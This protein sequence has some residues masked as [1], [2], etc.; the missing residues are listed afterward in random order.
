MLLAVLLV[1]SVVV[2]GAITV[3]AEATDVA[4]AEDF[5]A[6]TDGEY[7]LTEDITLTGT[8]ASFS[9]TL[10]GNGHTVTVSA[11]VFGTLSGTV[12]N[13]TIEGEIVS[14]ATGAVGAL[15]ST[16]SG[17]LTLENVTNKASVTASGANNVGGLI[18]EVKGSSGITVSITKCKNEGAISA[19]SQV[20]GLIGY[21]YNSSADYTTVSIT[22][23]V[24][25]GS[26]SM[27]TT[28]GNKGAGGFIGFGDKYT[29]V[30]IDKS[31]NSGAISATGGDY[32]VAGFYGGG[33]WARDYQILS[34]KNSANLGSVTI[35]GS[36][37]RGRIG[38]FVG[39]W[40]RR[41]LSC[42][43]ENCYNV[44]PI[45]GCGTSGNKDGA[46]GLLGYTN[47]NDKGDTNVITIKNC[48]NIGTVTA[49]YG[50]LSAIGFVDNNNKNHTVSEN[51]FYLAGTAQSAGNWVTGTE[52]ADKDALNA[53]LLALEN[54]PYIV[55][56][57]QNDGYAI[58]AWQCEH[59]ETVVTCLGNKCTSCGV[60]VD[61][62]GS[63]E[64]SYP[65]EW[66]TVDPAT[67]TEDGLAE[68]ICGICQ[69]KE[70]KT[71]DALGKIT[72]VDGVYGV[73]TEDQLVWLVY[74]INKG[75]IEAN[76][77][78]ALKAD[79]TLTNGLDMIIPTFNGSFDG[80][81]HTISGLNNALFKRVKNG[82]VFKNVTLNGDI[83]Y[84]AHE[85][86]EV[87][88]C[89]ASV[90]IYAEE[91]YLLENVV[92]NVNITIN[93]TNLNAA[94]LIGFANAGTIKNCT[95]AGTYT[96]TWTSGKGGAFGGMVG[97]LNDNAADTYITDCLFSG[98][99]VLTNAEAND[100]DMA[101]GGIVGRARNDAAKETITGCANIGT[102]EVTVSGS[103]IYVGGIVGAF[104]KK[105]SNSLSNSVFNGTITTNAP[106]CGT[107]VG[108]AGG[109]VPTTNCVSLKEGALVGQ[110][111]LAMTAC[112]DGASVEK[113]G[114]EFVRADV[115]YQKY[116]FGYLR[117][118][119]SMLVNPMTIP[120]DSFKGTLTEADNG[121]WKIA[122]DRYASFIS[123]RNGKK[124]TTSDLR[125]VLAANLAALDQCEELYVQIAFVKDGKTVVTLSKKLTEDLSVY[126]SVI[127]AGL[128]YTAEENVVL[129]G[130]VITDAPN[131]A[132]DE[133]QVAL[134]DGE[135]PLVSGKVT[136]AEAGAVT[137]GID[138]IA[139]G[140]GTPTIEDHHDVH[141]KNLAYASWV[142]E[143]D[144]WNVL[145]STG[146]P[147][148][149]NGAF[150]LHEGY[151]ATVIV[152]GNVRAENTFSYYGFT[153]EGGDVPIYGYFRFEVGSKEELMQNS[154]SCVLSVSLKIEDANGNV[155]C[156]ANFEDIKYT[157]LPYWPDDENPG[158]E[159]LGVTAISGPTHSTEGHE[160]LYDDNVNTKLCTSNRT[161][162]VFSLAEA[163]A[164]SGISLVTA[165]DNANNAGQSYRVVSGFTLYGCSTN[166]ENDSDWAIVLDVD[167]ANMGKDNFTEYY[168]AIDGASEYQY[169][170]IVFDGT[171]LF[172]F[173]ELWVYGN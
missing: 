31:L 59:K 25:A 138:L 39:R 2:I 26:V 38:G 133:V 152:N 23:S 168:Y 43:L 143:G 56:P 158:A 22:D 123:S 84:T 14:D 99:M 63:G 110:G 24:N 92:S 35:T 163:K 144:G 148:T 85:D 124:A 164:L 145:M 45:T 67:V 28:E 54:T 9:G 112:Y 170:K 95:Y 62:T 127:A 88:R 171:N 73:A 101:I 129:F 58:L 128:T 154:T 157:T 68:R 116:N 130:L 12:K 125:F 60:L 126:R 98:K 135:L 114:D 90:V 136:P 11:P 96:A 46:S 91:G 74:H 109:E 50:T 137:E 78:I 55:A 102:I 75:D 17:N 53:A 153:A 97:W 8:L 142:P 7:K 1:A 165:N 49:K 5:A 156:Y 13:L 87:H 162:V 167:Q 70:T 103:K 166:S 34:I 150:A 146:A 65:D 76:V 159:K 94:G 16:V 173:S 6:M 48:Y 47:S 161:P 42:T 4:S 30:S 118:D 61:E 172:Q 111:T 141:N 132:W 104:N 19:A 33:T 21:L 66:T 89:A 64:H 151:T 37:N 36:N 81:G 139:N 155:V 41:A 117:E 27:S 113:L 69:N 79:I 3:S 131:N 140:M 147:V 83:D 52:T 51:N 44:A 80:E 121:G 18:G 149:V 40:N 105:A 107:L 77:N 160:K 169:Y 57:S 93:T 120:A 100:N 122:T 71:V 29:N 82:F 115:S 119:T 15:A 10:D 72:P 108:F 20:G 134:S 32:G 106:V 86:G